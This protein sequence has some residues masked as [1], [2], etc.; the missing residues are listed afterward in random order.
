MPIGTVHVDD[1]P[2]YLYDVRDS[3]VL[4]L[5]RKDHR[6]PTKKYYLV[7]AAFFLQGSTHLAPKYYLLYV[8]YAIYI[9]YPKFAVC[10]LSHVLGEMKAVGTM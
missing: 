7:K 3:S 2:L 8:I 4:S 9:Y 1:F 5:G 10:V 6:D